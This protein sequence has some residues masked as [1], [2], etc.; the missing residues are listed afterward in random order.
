MKM[1][2]GVLVDRGVWSD[3]SVDEE[4]HVYIGGCVM[5]EFIFHF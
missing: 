4:M 3:A 2:M 5:N 1:W